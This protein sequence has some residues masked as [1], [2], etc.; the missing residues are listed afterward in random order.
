MA[1]DLNKCITI[2]RLT[3]DP[4][5]K[6]TQNGSSVCSFSL[7]VNYSYTSNGEKKE[8][9]SF[10][11][12][13]AWGKTGEAVAQYCK[14]GHRIAVEGRLQQ[15]SWETQDGTRRSVVEIVVETFQFLQP[16]ENGA[17]GEAPSGHGDIP[18]S[19]DDIPF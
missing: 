4:E 10:F 15:R 1:N 7:A 8:Q 2:G 17:H 13:V 11:N 19:G 3:K 5:L 12:Y 9:A 6:Y 14:K 16:R 18:P